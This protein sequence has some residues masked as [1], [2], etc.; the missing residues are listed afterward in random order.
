MNPINAVLGAASYVPATITRKALEKL[1]PKFGSYF[2]KALTYG[3]DANRAV[4]Y[5]VHRFKNQT[6]HIHEN[7]LEEGAAKGTL[8]P[9]EMV[10]RSQIQNAAIPGKIAKTALGI[11]TGLV[12]GGIGEGTS[13]IQKQEES[14]TSIAD[15][16]TQPQFDLETL[17]A[18]YPQLYKDLITKVQKGHPAEKAATLAKVKFPKEI[19]EIAKKIGA[20]FNS[21]FAQAL[22]GRQPTPNNQGSGAR[23]QILQGIGQLSDVLSKLGG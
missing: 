2:S 3:V 18:E 14:P 10:S 5:L 7:E 11:G 13:E 9:D 4:D 17:Q 23:S 6:Q 21:W 20:D 8:R 22:R 16:N 12:L 19:S 15:E 1:S